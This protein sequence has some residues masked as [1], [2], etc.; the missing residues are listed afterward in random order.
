MRDLRGLAPRGA[1]RR[2]T[3]SLLFFAFLIQTAPL[4]TPSSVRLLTVLYQWHFCPPQVPRHGQPE[5][6][7]DYDILRTPS[8]VLP[9]LST[10]MAAAT[11]AGGASSAPSGSTGS[12]S[13]SNDA[14]KAR[15]IGHM[16]RDHAPELAH[17]LRAFNG[18]SP[19]AARG[20]QIADLAL[21][22]LHIKTPAATHKVAISPSMTSLSESRVRLVDMAKQ[23]QAKL[24][25]SDIRITAYTAPRGAGIA[26]LAGVALYFVSALALPWIRPGTSAWDLLDRFFP[27]L[28]R[29]G[30]GGGGAEAFV[31]LVRV[32]M[33]PM[34]LVHVTEAWWMARTRLEKHGVEA[35][36]KVW[37]LWVGNT[38][39]EGVPAF[40]RFDGLVAAERARKDG[41]KH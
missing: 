3:A 34:L 27:S 4:P 35:G 19:R 12:S 33:V 16:N 14:M 25:L 23:A 31:W 5:T 39:F 41:A 1:V 6:A 30:G 29:G 26:S 38:F 7:S 36:S 15:I 40:Q 13:S 24:G 2:E 11:T 28:G 18:L 17:Y 10:A 37:L 22:A 21:D 32:I 20:A 8:L 9:Q